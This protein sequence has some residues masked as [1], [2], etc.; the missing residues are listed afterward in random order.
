MTLNG[1]KAVDDVTILQTMRTALTLWL[2]LFSLSVFSQSSHQLVNERLDDYREAYADIEFILLTSTDDFA[3]IH[4]LSQSLGKGVE[5]L[6]YEHPDELRQQL[7]EVQEY[8]ID[9]MLD[10][11]AGSA[12]LFSTPRATVTSKPY[13]CLITLNKILLGSDPLAATRMMYNFSE[14]DLEL[15]PPK[16]QLD[17]REF[18]LYTVD[19]EVF[20]CVDAY[21][22]GFM[23]P[24][25]FD[26]LKAC[27]DRAIAELKSEIFSAMA[28]V[29]RN[30][31][32]TGLLSSLAAARTLALLD[33]DVEHFTRDVLHD[34]S[35]NQLTVYS[36]INNLV[37]DAM[38]YFKEV[39]PT[40]EEYKTFYD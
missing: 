9:L 7:I 12:S 35:R 15:I 28:H 2:M 19:H 38:E 13:S 10:S 31:E 33:W 40:Q 26:P 24:Q 16:L 21:M 29:S 30:G 23:Y 20:H 22:H 11:G 18:L 36:N 27:G 34:I 37:P 14:E 8:R 32:K 3:E 25:T 39:R 6:D 5:N 4:P 17:N 1:R